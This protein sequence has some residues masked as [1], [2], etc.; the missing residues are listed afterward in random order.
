MAK[1]LKPF[2]EADDTLSE[3]PKNQA[4]VE[5]LLRAYRCGEAL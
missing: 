3:S 4:I 5:A 1:L 2:R